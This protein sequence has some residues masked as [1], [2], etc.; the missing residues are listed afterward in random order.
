[1][2]AGIGVCRCWKSGG[3]DF[4]LIDD[5]VYTTIENSKEPILCKEAF[6][7][8]LDHVVNKWI[9]ERLQIQWPSSTCCGLVM[10][11]TPDPGF[12]KLV[13]YLK[14]NVA[15]SFVPMSLPCLN[16]RLMRST[17]CLWRPSNSIFRYRLK[18]PKLFRIR[19]LYACAAAHGGGWSCQGHAL[20]RLL[21][22]GI[23][24]V[25][26]QRTRFIIDNHL[27]DILSELLDWLVSSDWSERKLLLSRLY[28]SSLHRADSQ[29]HEKHLAD[30]EVIVLD[31]ERGPVLKLVLDLRIELDLDNDDLDLYVSDVWW[32]KGQSLT[33]AAIREAG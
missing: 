12:V 20:Q 22:L 13:G 5:F 25:N 6:E 8:A 2:A 23:W 28:G 10:A 17:I 21:E 27:P 32:T 3:R 14:I 16:P 19:A 4:G 9:Q 29:H 15:D 31:G 26:H 1:M 33:V 30:Y 7:D 11:F 18:S 24:T